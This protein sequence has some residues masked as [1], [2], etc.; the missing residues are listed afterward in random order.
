MTEPSNKQPEVDWLE[1][2]ESMGVDVSREI[3]AY[4]KGACKPGGSLPARDEIET[5][6]SAAA[7]AIVQKAG[8]QAG[9]KQLDEHVSRLAT[10]APAS[11]AMKTAFSTTPPSGIA[12]QDNVSNI[13]NDSESDPLKA[14][15]VNEL[16]LDWSAPATPSGSSSTPREKTEKPERRKRPAKSAVAAAPVV[17][18]KSAVDLSS[19]DQLAS[20]LGIAQAAPRTGKVASESVTP[21]SA[22][23]ERQSQADDSGEQTQP[24]SSRSRERSGKQAHAEDA[25]LPVAPGKA[26]EGGAIP[27]LP[28]VATASSDFFGSGLIEP[29]APSA[30][31]GRH[32]PGAVSA[33]GF[34]ENA[35]SAEPD[36]F[37]S[38]E[39]EFD[40]DSDDGPEPA[41][42]PDI[43]RAW[44]DDYVEFEVEDLDPNARRAPRH[45]PQ[46][47][48]DHRSTS[49]KPKSVRP[50][51]VEVD[52]FVEDFGDDEEIVE[53][54]REMVDPDAID[55]VADEAAMRDE[56][57]PATRSSR[58]R[59]SRGRK[60]SGDSPAVPVESGTGLSEPPVAGRESAPQKARPRPV[61]APDDEAD[62]DFDG[63]EAEDI[64]SS[65]PRNLPTWNETVDVIVQANISSR[66]KQPPRRR[67][68]GGQTRGR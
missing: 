3:E 67:R 52:D 9:A 34:S 41:D 56:P 57:Q 7:Q 31:S 20:E 23:G 29:P 51:P 63:E 62:E 66:K 22:S 38:P 5:T 36:D 11:S 21:D 49:P 2:S 54:A 19:W 18:G 6:V 60:R 25:P 58:R 65:K 10:A 28:P 40:L 37:E 55:I 24:R 32:L 44:D 50:R 27:T 64:R 35:G 61:D 12:R 43:E 53:S 39:A 14:E 17:T 4:F 16:E 26:K 68:G 33:A 13:K 15:P 59:R 46:G 45:R 42:E 30:D 48:Q 1:I 8:L 47:G